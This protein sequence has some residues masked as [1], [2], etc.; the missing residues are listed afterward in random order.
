MHL[1]K[2]N[3]PN[4]RAGT[5]VRTALWLVSEVGIGNTFTK[6]LHRKVFS[7]VAQADRRLRDLR[8][9]GWIIHTSSDDV[10][11]NSNEQRFVAVGLPVW[12]GERRRK[13]GTSITAKERLAALA[14]T[15]FQCAVCGIAGGEHYPDAPGVSAVL[16]ISRR[17]VNIGDGTQ[18]IALIPECK[19][20][21][22]GFQS[23][24]IEARSLI[25]KV[26]ELPSAERQIFLQWAHA[27]R[28]TALDRLW[29]EYRRLP[30]ALRAQLAPSLSGSPDTHP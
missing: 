5:M 26:R 24:P 14:A 9:Y 8:A 13:S 2:W 7:S 30:P 25:A 12:D 4:L 15:D 1:P 20:C 27:G 18:T 10:T 23:G 16:S 6:E 11:L 22:A 21:R 28:S 29:F 3:D 19:R 17:A